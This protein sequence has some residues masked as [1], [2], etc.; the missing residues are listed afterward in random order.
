MRCLWL[1]LL[2]FLV[3]ATVSAQAVELAAGTDSVLIVYSA[4]IP[5]EGFPHDIEDMSELEA[6]T[7]ATPV[8]R[9][10]ESTARRIYDNLQAKGSRSGSPG[11]R[12]SR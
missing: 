8:E 10:T 5:F 11:R 7:S 12:N 2:L 1:S 3:P 4:G 6:V 9:N